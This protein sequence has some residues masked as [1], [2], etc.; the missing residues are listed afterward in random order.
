MIQWSEQNRL[1]VRVVWFPKLLPNY[2]SYL[3]QSLHFHK[4]TSFLLKDVAYG[5]LKDLRVILELVSLPLSI[6]KP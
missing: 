6:W 2:V 4:V 1:R 5:E 3:L